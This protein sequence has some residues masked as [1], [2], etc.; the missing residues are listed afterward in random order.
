MGSCT[1][2]NHKNQNLY[3]FKKFISQWKEPQTVLMAKD[4][5]MFHL[6]GHVFTLLV[7]KYRI[8]NIR[9]FEP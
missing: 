9:L 6:L 3:C 1:V 2:K 5:V 4:S 8:T 7:T